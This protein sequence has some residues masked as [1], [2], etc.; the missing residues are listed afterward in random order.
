MSTSTTPLESTLNQQ[1]QAIVNGVET[2]V[3]VFEV[4]GEKAG[5]ATL[6]IDVRSPSTVS[7]PFYFHAQNIYPASARR[8]RVMSV[9]DPL[10]EWVTLTEVVSITDGTAASRFGAFRGSVE[11]RADVAAVEGDGVVR[12][13]GAGDVL[14]LTYYGIVGADGGEPPRPH[15]LGR[16]R[17]LQHPHP[18]PRPRHCR[19]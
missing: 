4:T 10:G 8:V 6:I 16:F 5:G 2:S 3:E 1:H 13:D 15:L 17:H 18:R 19:T 14:Q 7:I 9:A 12:V 11:L